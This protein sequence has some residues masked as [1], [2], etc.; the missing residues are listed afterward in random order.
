MIMKVVIMCCFFFSSSGTICEA[1][2]DSK[3]AY[4]NEVYRLMDDMSGQPELVTGIQ[5]EITTVSL[6]CPQV[7]IWNLSLVL[8]TVTRRTSGMC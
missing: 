8:V 4:C 6:Y 5:T 2:V 7:F 3:K 1:F